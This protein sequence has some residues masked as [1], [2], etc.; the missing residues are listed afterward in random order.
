[1]ATR[2]VSKPSDLHLPPHADLWIFGYGSLMWDPGFP[3]ID[4]RQALLRGFHR[5]FCILSTIYR[6]TPER[7][8]LVLGLDRGGACRGLALRVAAGMVAPTLAYL[9]DREM[10]NEV[11]RPRLLPVRTAG[12]RITA[13]AFTVARGHEQYCG[14]LCRE[15]TAERICRAVGGRGPNI[16]YLAN[17]VAHLRDLGIRDHGLEDLLLHVTRK[18]A[19]NDTA[20]HQPVPPGGERGVVAKAPT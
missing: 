19:G 6:G 17:T 1:M 9:W 14:K 11:Y 5:S 2:L 20:P 12:E 13:L 16:D 3:F 15:E 10:I 4:C 8:G 18:L 7:P